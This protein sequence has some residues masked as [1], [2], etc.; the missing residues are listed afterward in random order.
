MFVSNDWVPW[1]ASVPRFGST[2]EG[3]GGQGDLLCRLCLH[4]CTVH[5]L[6]L[7][8]QTYRSRAEAL[9]HRLSSKVQFS[10]QKAVLLTLWQGT[11]RAAMEQVEKKL[12][13]Y[14]ISD[15]SSC[16]LH[17]RGTKGIP[18]VHRLLL[19]NHQR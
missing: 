2:Q 11:F 3:W 5:L 6:C 9:S 15:M 10:F 4:L 14:G 12:M 7:Q 19:I 8:C 13:C 17:S 16:V 1:T 18:Q